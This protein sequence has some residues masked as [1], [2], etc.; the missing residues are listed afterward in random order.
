LGSGVPSRR[1]NAGKSPGI[2]R[3]LVASIALGS[4]ALVHCGSPS[5]AEDA[6]A[7]S[8]LPAMP[9][10]ACAAGTMPSLGQAACVPVG[11]SVC[12]DGFATGSAGWGC[13]AVRP[14]EACTGA[15]RA[16]IGST[17]CVAVSD[18]DAP[19][20]PAGTE[21]VVHDAASLTAALARVP[22]ARTIALDSGTYDG[23]ELAGTVHLVGRC[24]SKVTLKGTGAGRGILV[25]GTAKVSVKGVTITGFKGAVVAA[26]GGAIDLAGVAIVGNP[27]GIVASAGT[28][29][30]DGALFEGPPATG[31]R[32]GQGLAAVTSEKGGV[33][34]VADADIRNFEAAALAVDR[35]KATLRRSIVTSYAMSSYPGHMI[36]AYSEGVVTVEESG[37]YVRAPDQSFGLAGRV[38]DTVTKDVN[39]RPGQL[40]IVSSELSKPDLEDPGWLFGVHEG[41][42][43]EV[44]GSTITHRADALFDVRDAETMLSL[45]NSTIISSAQTGVPHT[46]V[47]VFSGAAADLDGVAFVAPSSSAIFVGDVGSRVSF[48]R[49]LVT[50]MHSGAGA[51]ALVSDRQASLTLD[52]S[53]VVD[54]EGYALIG[55]AGS[56][57]EIGSSFFD[58]GGTGLG[59]AVTALSSLSMNR[60]VTRRQADA[61]LTFVVGAQGV[62]TDSFFLDNQVAIHLDRA[63]IK[64]ATGA[65]QPAG[66]GEVVLVRNTFTNN[67][68]YLST[69]PTMLITKAP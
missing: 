67:V 51:S 34:T 21:V 59:V 45:K 56:K 42:R 14:A 5:A 9:T 68:E 27:Y 40:R 8:G 4:L 54:S 6:P 3:A 15:M 58:G 64:D 48:A 32:I 62:V 69:A 31:P 26:S 50:G 39:P 49:S 53:A 18:C 23:V 55:N 19:F 22:A 36:A 16:R 17:S 7:T 10:D 30:V 65:A 47:T 1:T 13:A 24:A 33:V 57:I 12:P 66:D 2:A 61:A 43:V 28:V 63:H 60:C 29:N 11:A 20:P 52:G 44:E 38:L 35:G 41:A 46:G 25:Q 37:L